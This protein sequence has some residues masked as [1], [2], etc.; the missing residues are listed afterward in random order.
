M[1][2]SAWWRERRARVLQLWGVGV[3]A[4]LLVT[5]ASALGYLE[6]LQARSGDLLLRLQGQRITTDVVVVGIDEAAFESVGRRQ[7]LPREYLTRVIRGLERAGAA[8]VGVDLDLGAATTPAEDAM[9]ARAIAGFSDGGLS[10]V[11]T[12]ES[13]SPK[14]GGPLGH[15]DLTATVLRGAAEVPIDGDG[16]I[17]RAAFLVAPGSAPPEPALSVA[18]A[19]RLAGLDRPALEAMVQ[20]GTVPLPRRNGGT[21]AAA[22]NELFRINFL[23]PAGTFLTIPSDAIVALADPGVD[24]ARDNPVNGR[25]VLVGATFKDSRDIH[26]TPHGLMP[27]VEIHATLVYTLMSGSWIRPSGFAT[28]LVVQI[29]IVLIAGLVMALFRPLVGTLVCLAGAVGLG[30]PASYL[31]FRRSGYWVDFLL[32]VLVTTLLGL[33]AEALA[34]RRFRDSFSRY[35]SREI[36]AQVLAEAPSLRGERR[37][38]SIL[39]SDLRGFTTLSETMPAEEVAARLTEYFE[40]MT[41][42][43][44]PH[45]GMINDFVGDGIVAVFGAPL[46]DPDHAG[47]AVA[48]AID[49][50]RAL[51]TLNEQWTAARLPTLEMG[52]GV[53]TGQV[54][55]GNVGGSARVKYTMVGDPV[56]LASRVEGLN[57]ELKTSML[58]T[59]ETRQRVTGRVDLRDCGLMTVKGRTQPVHVF[60]LLAFRPHG[61]AP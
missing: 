4:S 61:G 12:V 47:N 54:F 18:V 1:T 3:V 9:L 5:G 16:V 42:A 25:V 33:V 45:R 55:I 51:R 36:V 15:P 13:R 52:I 39:F 27:G 50:A 21:L 48:A 31:A 7:P 60:E 22:P 10:R 43:I 32:P 46:R 2:P 38:V 29:I 49:M 35:V 59:E 53:H 57:K 20:K 8:A 6:A 56:N 41:A 24:V 23:G 28:S 11:V 37:E 34:R 44:F 19:A 58:I 14:G 30:I 17:R 26:W 40:A